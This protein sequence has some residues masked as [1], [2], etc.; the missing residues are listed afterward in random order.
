MIL[1]ER[2]WVLQTFGSSRSHEKSS[3]RKEGDGTAP[4]LTE[5]LPTSVRR[6]IG[7]SFV[8]RLVFFERWQLH[9]NS[10]GAGFAQFFAGESGQHYGDIILAAALVCLIY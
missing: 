10:I 6:S 2:S 4:S 3:M 1:L 8:E 7:L 5:L 9:G